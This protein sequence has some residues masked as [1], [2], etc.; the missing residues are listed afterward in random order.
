MAGTREIERL[1][2]AQAT[3]FDQLATK[4]ED[5]RRTHAASDTEMMRRLIEDCRLWSQ[6]LRG[7]SSYLEC[8]A[9]WYRRWTS[10]E[11][12]YGGRRRA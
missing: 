1:A 3:G 12:E 4:L 10:S 6:K 7:A 9:W 2:R 11:S 8:V 5:T